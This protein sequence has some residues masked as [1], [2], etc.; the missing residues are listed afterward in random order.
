MLAL[1]GAYVVIGARN[2]EA[3]NQVKQQ[4]LNQNGSARV[5]VLKLDLCSFKSVGE[6]VHRFEALNLPLHILM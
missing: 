6:F 3:A 2:L 1:R 4:I 5:T